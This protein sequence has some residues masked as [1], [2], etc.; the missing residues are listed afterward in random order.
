MLDK[1][2]GLLERKAFLAK[3][4]EELKRAVR[5]RRPFGFLMIDL[6]HNHFSQDRDVRWSMGYSLLKQLAAVLKSGLRDVDVLGRFDGEVFGAAL[7]E[8]DVAGAAIAAERV[9]KTVADHWFMGTTQEDRV[10]V[11]VNVGFVTFPEHGDTIQTLI[12]ASKGALEKAKTEGGN[13]VVEGQR[14]V[15]EEGEP[16]ATPQE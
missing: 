12:E 2:S 7:P 16:E 4:D 9:R 6:A 15:V 11:A 13:R 14:I 5:Y 3:V 8:T 1:L 10:R